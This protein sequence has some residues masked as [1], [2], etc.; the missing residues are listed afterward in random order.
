V[1]RRPTPGGHRLKILHRGIRGGSNPAYWRHQ[2][3]PP[4]RTRRLTWRRRT[5]GQ[6]TSAQ[7]SQ[8]IPPKQNDIAQNI[9]MDAA[10]SSSGSRFEVFRHIIVDRRSQLY[11]TGYRVRFRVGSRNPSMREPPRDAEGDVRSPDWR[12]VMRRLRARSKSEPLAS[13]SPRAS[14]CRTKSSSRSEANASRNVK[15]LAKDQ[16]PLGGQRLMP[17]VT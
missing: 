12:C 8:S 5:F 17:H 11:L 16:C 9:I 4:P 15:R 10:G 14:S 1:L 3:L 2:P 13:T 7:A 6:K